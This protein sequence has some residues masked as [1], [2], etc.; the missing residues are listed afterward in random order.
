MTEDSIVRPVPGVADR[1]RALV[2]R[3]LK[4]AVRAALAFPSRLG[5]ARRRRRAETWLDELGPVHDVLVMCTGNI[6]RSPYVARKLERD[7]P[8]GAATLVVTSAGFLRSDRPSPVE[9]RDAAVRRGIDL[10]SHR[11]VQVQAADLEAAG[12]VLVM[13]EEQR[14]K[15]ERMAPG[16][17]G[18]I[19]LLGEL[20]P[21]ALQTP[22][23]PDPWG[24]PP[25]TFDRCYE[26]LDR[27]VDRL[28][29]ALARSAR[30]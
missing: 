30:G 19:L 21:A 5:H 8:Q 3:W 17:A 7:V 15:V 29:S 10:Q 9:A 13:E 18:R 26:R 11:S 2:P 22:D 20:D 27:C 23:V 14:R 4:R 28:A 6:C 12:L 1:I 25:E 24:H 16:A